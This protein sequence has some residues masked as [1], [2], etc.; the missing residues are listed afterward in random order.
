MNPGS[1]RHSKVDASPE[2]RISVEHKTPFWFHLQF[3]CVSLFK[4]CIVRALDTPK[5]QHNHSFAK[6]VHNRL[7][8]TGRVDI[9]VN[10]EEMLRCGVAFCITISVCAH[11][12]ISPP[13]QTPTR[14]R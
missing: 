8:V 7:E 10:V 1:S 5:V 14:S 2:V 13:H 11:R 12:S 3:S 4:M 6:S 9:E